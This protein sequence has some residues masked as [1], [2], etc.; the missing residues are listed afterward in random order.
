MSL[1]IEE[2][3]RERDAW[4]TI[5][6]YVFQVQ[7]SILEWLML[8]ETEI[9][10]VEGYEDIEIYLKSD[11]NTRRLYQI[12]HREKSLT[13]RRRE[14]IE[15]LASFYEYKTKRNAH[16]GNVKF[17]YYTNASIGAEQKSPF[18][19]SETISG[20][21]AIEV[22]EKIRTEKRLTEKFVKE[23]ICGIRKLLIQYTPPEEKDFLV[24]WKDFIQSAK[25]DELELWIHNVQWESTNKSVKDNENY[26]LKLLEDKGYGKETN[27]FLQIYYYLFNKVFTLMSAEGI[28]QMSS[29]DLNLAVIEAIK[30]RDLEFIT[31]ELTEVITNKFRSNEK[32]SKAKQQ[33]ELKKIKSYIRDMEH[34]LE[35]AIGYIDT[36]LLIESASIID[37]NLYSAVET[38]ETLVEPLFG[39]YEATLSDT[40]EEI[41]TSAL[42]QLKDEVQKINL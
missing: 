35:Q 15:A 34:E 10:Q 6:G 29:K 19:D 22:W 3:L 18:K 13:L 33:A 1:L 9:L 40:Q 30:L 5:R 16:L 7:V 39:E 12:K 2:F 17:K 27:D 26:I 41:I 37:D 31:K 4:S 20:K 25:D 32:P 21:K 11:S 14:A 23:G 8:E 38:F 42:K 36:N 24:K 28:K